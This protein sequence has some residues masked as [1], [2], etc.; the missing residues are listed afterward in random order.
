MSADEFT[1]QEGPNLPNTDKP[2]K[3]AWVAA[4]QKPGEES[5][6]EIDY[7]V[8]LSNPESL[9]ARHRS[10]KF[11]SRMLEHLRHLYVDNDHISHLH[12]QSD[13]GL[14]VLESVGGGEAARLGLSLVQ[15]LLYHHHCKS[16][17]HHIDMAV[18]FPEQHWLVQGGNNANV[19]Q[20]PEHEHMLRIR[21]RLGELNAQLL[22]L[23]NGE[24]LEVHFVPW[25]CTSAFV[26]LCI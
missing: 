7:Q 10:V 16:A 23:R 22:S 24:P 5:A 9:H 11:R 2:I 19:P 8:D 3:Q 26:S 1:A 4:D 14:S 21:K 18:A 15:R 25:G 12:S 17:Q 13:K 20:Y 6:E